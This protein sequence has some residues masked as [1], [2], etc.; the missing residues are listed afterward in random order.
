METHARALGGQ[1]EAQA[2][3]ALGHEVPCMCGQ[4]CWSG[5]RT[6]TKTRHRGGRRVGWNKVAAKLLCDL[7]RPGLL[8][9]SLHS[10]SQ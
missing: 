9:A 3:G 8:L 1:R 6:G 2:A 7:H 5:E 10:L 4:S